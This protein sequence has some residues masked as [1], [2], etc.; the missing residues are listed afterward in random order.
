MRIILNKR[1]YDELIK[2]G[3]A[4]E[5]VLEERIEAEKAKLRNTLAIQFKILM[6]DMGNGLVRSEQSLL[7]RLR[8]ILKLIE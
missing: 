5:L 3:H 1:E 7:S 2:A 4:T 6:T 8:D